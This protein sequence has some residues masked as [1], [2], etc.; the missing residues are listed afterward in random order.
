MPVCSVTVTGTSR[1]PSRPDVAC[2]SSPV[3]TPTP[4][5]R[6]RTS[7]RPPPIDDFCAFI[8]KA[9]MSQHASDAFAS[10]AGSPEPWPSRLCD[11]LC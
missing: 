3:G 5:A 8:A 2:I 9:C 1:P 10:A 11:R 7:T 4:S 6:P